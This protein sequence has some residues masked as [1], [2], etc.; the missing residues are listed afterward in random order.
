[1]GVAQRYQKMLSTTRSACRTS[2]STRCTSRRP[3]SGPSRTRPFPPRSSTGWPRPPSPPKTV[4]IVTSKFPSAQFMSRGARDVAEKRGLK[5]VALPRVRVRHARLGRDRRARQGRQARLPLGGRARPRRQ[6]APR[7]D[8]EARLHAAAA[9]PPVP[10]ARAAGH[11]AR[12]QAGALDHAT[13]RSIRRSPAI[14]RPRG[15]SPSSTS[16][17]PRPMC[18]TPKVDTQAAGSFAAWQVLEAAVTATKS[19]DD[20]VLGEWLRKNPVDTIDRP[21]ALRRAQQLR[22]R[23]V[24]GEAGAGRQVGRGVAEGVRGAGRPAAALTGGPLA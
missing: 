11:R 16:A 15:W 22:R 4:A 6:S 13:S 21:A 3:P 7:G 10:G 2:P 8:E 9:L 19:L 1:M 18:R 5:V 23:P 20:K 12:R 24:Q 17:P 14:R